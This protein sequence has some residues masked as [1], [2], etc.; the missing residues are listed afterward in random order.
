MQSRK[1]GKLHRTV[2]ALT[3][4]SLA[5]SMVFPAFAAPILSGSG[6]G[7]LQKAAG[8]STVQAAEDNP[9]TYREYT[10]GL[11]NVV[12]QSWLFVGTYLMSAKAVNAR[13][14]QG[15]L[16]SREYYDQYIAYYTSEL[17]GGTWKNVKDAG[18]LST[19]LPLATTVKE[20]ELYPYYITVVVGDD[21]IPRDPVTG[22]PIDIYNLIS[23]YDMEN[24]KELD[25]L[26]EYFN[27]GPL[28]AQDTG[29]SHYLFR[30]L[31]Y[32]FEN[33]NLDYDRASLDVGLAMLQYAQLSKDRA[34]LEETWDLA[35][36]RSPLVYPEEYRE[37]MLVMRNW[38]NI[39]DDVTDLAD[40]QEAA[41]DQMAKSFQE[42][43]KSEEADAAMYVQRQV[44]ATRRAEIFY[45]L[46]ENENLTGSYGMDNSAAVEELQYRKAEISASMALLAVDADKAQAPATALREEVLKLEDEIET[47]AK[48]VWEAEETHAQEDP[49]GQLE[50]LRATLTR[51]QEEFVPIQEEFTRLDS[52]VEEILAEVTVLNEEQ[53]KKSA[54][55][56]ELRAEKYNTKLDTYTKLETLE[57]DLEDLKARKSAAESLRP[58]YE[59][60]LVKRAEMDEKILKL[61]KTLVT[62]N[63]NLETLEKEADSYT[64]SRFTSMMD[65]GKTYDPA[66][67]TEADHAVE[68][69]KKLITTLED[70]KSAC[71]TEKKVAVATTTQIAEDLFL[72][73]TIA[74]AEVTL[75]EY[76]ASYEKTLEGKLLTLDQE[77]LD[78]ENE[79]AAESIPYQ[80]KLRT[81]KERN[82]AYTAY[83]PVYL[84]KKNEILETGWAIEDL[85]K[86]I[87]RYQAGIQKKLE[88]VTEDEELIAAKNLMI[89]DV[90]APVKAYETQ[91]TALQNEADQLEELLKQEQAA[92]SGTPYDNVLSAYRNQKITL[93][94]ERD[95]LQFAVTEKEES[96]KNAL[97]AKQECMD[98]I[99]SLQKTVLED[100][101]GKYDEDRQNLIDQEDALIRGFEEE[102]SKTEDNKRRALLTLAT[103]QK[104]REKEAEE[105]K[106]AAYTE[107]ETALSAELKMLELENIRA[108]LR[109]KLAS[110]E[111][112]KQYYEGKAGEAKTDYIRDYF[113]KEADKIKAEMEFLNSDESE[114][115]IRINTAETLI[116]NAL[117]ALPSYSGSSI[118]EM[119]KFTDACWDEYLTLKEKEEQTFRDHATAYAAKEQEFDELIAKKAEIIETEKTRKQT[120]LEELRDQFLREQE[121]DIDELDRRREVLAQ[122]DAVYTTYAQE[123]TDLKTRMEGKNAD[124]L[125]TDEKITEVQALIAEY[126]GSTSFGTSPTLKFLRAAA[127]NG[128]PQVGRRYEDI[129]TYAEAEGFTQDEQLLKIIDYC[130][131]NCAVAYTFYVDKSMKR[132]ETA[133]DYVGFLLSRKT[134][135]LAPD[136]EAALPYL[137]MI[138]D[139]LNI[140]EKRQTV[141]ARR[142]LSLLYGW[143]LPFAMTDFTDKRT[144]DSMDDYHFYIK[145]VADRE[146]LEDAITYV[147]GRLEYAYSIKADFIYQGKTDLINAHIAWLEDLLQ[148]LREQAGLEDDETYDEGDEEYLEE[149]ER[150]LEEGNLA[151][152]A[153]IADLLDALGIGGR[154]DGDDG[155]G[156]D[157][158]PNDL[159]PTDSDPDARPLPKDEIKDMILDSIGFEDYDIIPD[160]IRYNAA[161]GDLGD[162]LNG[163]EKR[164]AGKDLVNAVKTAQLD[165]QNGGNGN[166]SFDIAGGDGSDS[167]GTGTD[168]NGTG[169]GPGTGGGGSLMTGAGTG[170]TKVPADKLKASMDGLLKN[171]DEEGKAAI[172]AAL[173]DYAAATDDTDI[174]DYL[175]SLLDDLLRDGSTCIYRQYLDDP[176]KEYVSLG[177]IDKCRVRSGFRYVR[178]DQEITMS[179]LYGG[180]ASY[181][182]TVGSDVMT[183]NNGETAT[184][185][186]RVVEQTDSYLRQNS[187]TK[188]GYVAEG[189]AQ[190]Y[191]GNTCV[192]IVKTDWAVL[193]TPGMEQKIKE[194][195]D[196]INAMMEAQE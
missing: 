154:L 1:G 79:L 80:E 51:L 141:H 168:G 148:K 124:I 134:A 138:T 155:N 68:K 6:L 185:T 43:E 167:D 144:V 136:E 53:Q 70:V 107:Y 2:F 109:D 59:D 35:L 149:Y 176:S 81:L 12:P 193:V 89:T 181:T 17:D 25:L 82:D 93:L 178:V 130:M 165:K 171:A 67:K 46:L 57:N 99:E 78:L 91:I 113:L 98:S 90:E 74:Q 4:W 129:A 3:S 66:K 48:E 11:G 20:E 10:V 143:L 100:R 174:W 133:S 55:I 111:E 196:I 86:E 18:S 19:I 131:G 76:N 5:L 137:Q 140:T 120:L 187:E 24:I 108:E 8:M 159:L 132:G 39:R 117:S 156:R 9:I 49:E 16:D 147:E 164:G 65:S 157:R 152:A 30:M 54:R 180:S 40:S 128:R 95:A 15:A 83:E 123:L 29:T 102:K 145:A 166:G 97:I 64:S 75:A 31:Y 195:T 50:T 33:D 151:R 106:N 88:K 146:T 23:P 77:I 63:A 34:K 115:M 126:P 22:D 158:N 42:A 61:E 190:R 87:E 172:L 125:R 44:D 45:N 92:K 179:Q 142:E 175:L 56:D 162:L 104:L 47:I 127:E 161:D 153:M 122:L 139:L 135:M 160:L 103:E 37:I 110:L 186:T 27:D 114:I 13:I 96:K 182:F 69:Q 183:K 184:L 21:G 60:A 105:E 188:Y 177:A 26:E 192:Y 38:P 118:E 32:F 163:L 41:L 94:Q 71:E 169:N 73:E 194:V 101:Q 84:E 112:E 14:Y 72:D 189:D 119:M 52:A 150:A 7:F 121:T 116:E 28:E 173:A 170:K 85:E 58:Q 36:T 62:E 191:L